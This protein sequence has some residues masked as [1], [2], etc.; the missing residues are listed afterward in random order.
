MAAKAARGEEVAAEAPA[1]SAA[2]RRLAETAERDFERGLQ[3]LIAAMRTEA[4][5]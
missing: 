2:L 3:V 1:V 5:G 4:R